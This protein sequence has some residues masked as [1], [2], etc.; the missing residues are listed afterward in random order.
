MIHN[1]SFSHKESLQIAHVALYVMQSFFFPR[2]YKGD[3][4][5][6]VFLCSVAQLFLC[7]TGLKQKSESLRRER[8]LDTL[9]QVRS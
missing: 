1:G 8:F 5:L 3:R 6:C 9:F 2:F 7:E 4:G